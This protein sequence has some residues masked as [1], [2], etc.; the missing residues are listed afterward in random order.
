MLFMRPIDAI[1]ERS[2][3]SHR[4]SL[5]KRQSDMSSK[6]L[7]K[8]LFSSELSE[9]PYEDKAFRTVGDYETSEMDSVIYVNLH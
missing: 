4:L 5:P 6:L 3:S 1:F 8:N 7:W 9:K 2:S